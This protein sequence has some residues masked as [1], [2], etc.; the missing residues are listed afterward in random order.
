MIWKNGLPRSTEEDELERDL[1]EKLDWI[2]I[3]EEESSSFKR[4]L[5]ELDELSGGAFVT[6]AHGSANK[7]SCS[8]SS[9]ESSNDQHSTRES[10]N[11]SAPEQCLLIIFG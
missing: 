11:S 8:D 2:E 6:Q 3:E 5:E 1:Q 9:N 10:S 4:K 7:K